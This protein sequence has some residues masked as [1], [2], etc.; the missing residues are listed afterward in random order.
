MSEREQSE[1][2]EAP[3]PLYRAPRGEKWS[4]CLDCAPRLS[5]AVAVAGL[6]DTKTTLSI[7]S[8]PSS[9]PLA[10]GSRFGT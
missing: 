8:K 6:G 4:G 10:G 5:E 9:S 7:F 3:L 2:D 1:D